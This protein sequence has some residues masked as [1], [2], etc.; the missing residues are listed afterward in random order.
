MHECA[1]SGEPY[2]PVD[3]EVKMEDD[4]FKGLQEEIL[5][6]LEG[7]SVGP[8]GFVEFVQAFYHAVTVPQK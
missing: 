4:P 7:V 3:L 2:F 6:G 5:G 8:Q 1:K